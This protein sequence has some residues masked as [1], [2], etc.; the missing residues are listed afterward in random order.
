MPT[1][2]STAKR[3]ES[4]L[5]VA[6]DYAQLQNRVALALAKQLSAGKRTLGA[7]TAAQQSTARRDGAVVHPGRAGSAQ[8]F[9]TLA[10]AITTTTSRDGQT[11][12]RDGAAAGGEEGAKAA[13]TRREMEDD[14][15]AQLAEA[16]PINAGIGSQ[17]AASAKQNEGSSSWGG[18]PG[19]TEQDVKLGRRLLGRRP[20]EWQEKAGGRREERNWNASG[21]GGLGSA[22][23]GSRE[24][25]G[26]KRRSKLAADESESDEEQG[27]SALGRKKRRGGR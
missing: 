24:G 27:R 3:K 19:L 20:Q 14:R 6:P 12:A 1:A 26:A 11:S 4:A 7:V 10:T 5:P 13:V 8:G 18:R 9:S 17:P 16:L 21:R 2:A 15:A 22:S 25:A 23:G